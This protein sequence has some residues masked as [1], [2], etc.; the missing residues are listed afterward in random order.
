MDDDSVAGSPRR[1]PA[2]RAGDAGEGLVG[3]RLTAAGWTIL[4]RNVRLGRAEIDLLA[5]D[6]GPP[7]QL[8]IVEVRWRTD[9][10]YGLPEETVDWR[11]RRQLRRALVRLVETQS[12]PDGRQ[13]PHLPT[14]IDIV[15]LEPA[16]EGGQLRM[17]HHRWA[18]GG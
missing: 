11:K 8:V 4:W 7:P 10:G 17:R 5:V 12:L 2:Q 6:P 16:P 1:T 9:R 14:R 13:I 3:D 15:A 18:V